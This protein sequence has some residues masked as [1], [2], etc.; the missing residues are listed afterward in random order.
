MNED[1]SQKH[2]PLVEGGTSTSQQQLPQINSSIC[3]KV[4]FPTY[5]SS[6]SSGV[7]LMATVLQLNRTERPPATLKAEPFD[8]S[9][10][11]SVMS[12]YHLLYHHT[13]APIHRWVLSHCIFKNENRELNSQGRHRST[14]TDFPADARDHQLM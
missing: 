13:T 4:L 7:L 11:I 2:C 3:K 5:L 6:L 1:T 10:L 12:S 14:R 8:S 9:I